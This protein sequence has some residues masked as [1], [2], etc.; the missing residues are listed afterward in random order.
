[1]LPGLALGRGSSSGHVEA[2]ELALG[3]LLLIPFAAPFMDR[4]ELGTWVWSAPRYVR[5]PKPT[6]GD[7]S[8]E[9]ISW[10]GEQTISGSLN[11]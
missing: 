10:N 11:L 9:R 3:E 5:L 7:Y 6:D 1:M 4:S 8:E 2:C